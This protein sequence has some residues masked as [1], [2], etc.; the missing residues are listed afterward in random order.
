MIILSEIGVKL[1]LGDE[2]QEYN[3]VSK[4]L[5]PYF[6]KGYKNNDMY[7]NILTYGDLIGEDNGEYVKY[8]FAELQNKN[9]G[10]IISCELTERTLEN[11]GQN[12]LKMLFDK[13]NNELYNYKIFTVFSG[14]MN[15]FGC[16]DIY[17]YDYENL[18]EVQ[19]IVNNKIILGE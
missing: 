3:N 15:M 4:E 12:L 11:K 9:I 17:F 16:I 13:G 5:K 2:W 7:I 18:K 6:Y 10:R 1:D 8:K 19:Y 14:K